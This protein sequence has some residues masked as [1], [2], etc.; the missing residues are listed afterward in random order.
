MKLVNDS[1]LRNKPTLSSFKF[2]SFQVVQRR[3]DL[4]T[5]E[6]ITF[7]TGVKIGKD[8][9]AKDLLDNNDALLLCLGSTWPRDL[10]IPG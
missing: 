9:S 3:I 2:P 8:V 10:P 6:G 4:L 5:A 1:M 7:K